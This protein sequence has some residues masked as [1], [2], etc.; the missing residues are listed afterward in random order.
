MEPDPFRGLDIPGAEEAGNM[1]PYYADCES[2]ITGAGDLAAIR[3][4]HPEL[5][6]FSTWLAAPSRSE[7]L[8]PGDTCAY[9]D[10][11]RHA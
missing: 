2:R 1:S 5:Q 3:G 7:T 6:D 9:T 10:L 4:L 11:R 8:T